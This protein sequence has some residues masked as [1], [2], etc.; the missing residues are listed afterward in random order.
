MT[1]SGPILGPEADAL[2]APLAVFDGLVLAVSGGADSSALLHLAG[3][4][5]QRR[6]ER[7]QPVPEVVV[8]IVDHGLR[9]E[10]RAEAEQVGRVAARL[11]LSHAVL[12]WQG[13]KPVSRI[14]EVARGV[15][16]ELLTSLAA[17]RFG[18]GRKTAV[19]TAHTL[20]DQSETLLMRLA[21]GSGID[22]LA[23]MAPQTRIHETWLVRPLLGVGH[24]R[25]VATLVAAGEAWIEDPS[26]GLDRF[27]RVRL[28][29]ARPSLDAIGLRLPMLG[30]GARRLKR[31]RDCLE[32]ATRRAWEEIVAAPLGAYVTIGRGEFDAL[33]EEIRVRLLSMALLRSGGRSPAARLKAV[34][35]TVER[36]ATPSF[37]A[38]T[39]GGV[40][41]ERKDNELR[42]FR[43]PGRSG[44][45]AVPLEAGARVVWDRRFAVS[46]TREGR[47]G[48]VVA[49]VGDGLRA[50]RKACEAAV[51]LPARAGRALP[52]IWL[53]GVLI[54]VPAFGWPDPSAGCS[55]GEAYTVEALE[56]KGPPGG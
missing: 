40:L 17:Q 27:E 29:Q 20:D 2:L 18:P 32:A 49:A 54:A 10:S 13:R 3:G 12:E 50:V 24:E 53:D 34:E 5:L 6:S 55:D 33:D 38:C 45:E 7:S 8:G 52:G 4:W 26:N 1:P 22:G 48:A 56:R 44:L 11:K 23:A 42:L 16:Y 9:S 37:S 51:R 39:L 41:V 46:A 31:A 15:R 47:P 30:L 43:E 36:L 35:R 28:R 19:V 25:L 21:R 14:Q